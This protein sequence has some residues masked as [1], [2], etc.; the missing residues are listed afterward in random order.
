MLFDLFGRRKEEPKIDF[1][2]LGVDMHSHL[3]PGIDDGAQSMEDSIELIKKLAD[4]GFKKLVTT[5]HVM[6]DFYRNTPEIIHQGLELV[7]AEL[8]KN[9]IA[10]EIEAAAEYYFDEGLEDK[11]E[12]GTV[13]SL[14]S[15]F[16]LFEVSFLSFPRSFYEVVEKILTKG[17]KPVLAHPERYGYFAGSID[18]FERIKK[19]GCYLQL[20]ALSLI[21]YYGK[22]AQK[23]AQELV[24]RK[25]ID[26]LGTDIHHMKHAGMLSKALKNPYI[27][28]LLTNYPLQNHVLL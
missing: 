26:F 23:I 1:S 8:K 13:L 20:N 28:H 9:E 4:L 16:L 14:G 5:P 3:I 7:R 21:G 22:S 6:A 19:S 11:I 25:L 2:L 12:K 24:D 18:Q 15:G 17:Y 10:V 27:K